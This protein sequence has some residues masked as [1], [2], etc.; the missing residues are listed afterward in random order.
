CTHYPFLEAE[1]AAALPGVRLLDP[2]VAQTENAARFVM[3]RGG[4]EGGTTRYVTTGPLDAFRAGV[5]A[6]AGTVDA[7]AT[8][9][10]IAGAKLI[11]TV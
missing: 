11:E 6:I 7:R 5:M 3:A 2:A 8:F 1:F 4:R 10:R 9:E